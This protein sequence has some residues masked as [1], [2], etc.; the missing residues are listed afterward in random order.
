MSGQGFL[1]DCEPG[2]TNQYGTPISRK[3]DPDTSKEAGEK[4]NVGEQE[5]QV[6]QWL[7]SYQ[8]EKA[9]EPTNWELAVYVDSISETRMNVDKV[10]D[11]IHKRMAG[12]VRKG[13]VKVTGSRKDIFKDTNMQTRA[14]AK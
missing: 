11:I 10:Y 14:I 1:F 13:R 4:V 12:L 9:T 5:Q 7:A 2:R 3:T 6:Y 8:K